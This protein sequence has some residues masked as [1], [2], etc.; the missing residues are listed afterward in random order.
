MTRL[1]GEQLY[2]LINVS[3]KVELCRRRD[4]FAYPNDVDF[5]T[6]NALSSCCACYS[7]IIKGEINKLVK[8]IVKYNKHKKHRPQSARLK[9][10]DCSAFIYSQR[11]R[12][13]Y[14]VG[15]VKNSLAKLR[16]A[17]HIALPSQSHRFSSHICQ[18]VFCAI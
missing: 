10:L 11:S 18:V 16:D 12:Y 14:V 17:H 3:L 7:L 9:R 2:N 8:N 6:A 1:Q 5:K 13:F 4:S 15:Y